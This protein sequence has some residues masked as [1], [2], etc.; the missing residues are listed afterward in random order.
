[1]AN[2]LQEP[3]KHWCENALCTT[4]SWR[5]MLNTWVQPPGLDTP[6]RAL[7]AEDRQE[8][9]S[10]EKCFAPLA[11]QHPSESRAVEGEQ[12]RTW[13]WAAW[14][15]HCI[16]ATVWCSGKPPGSD[17]RLSGCQG[18]QYQAVHR[19]DSQVPEPQQLWCAEAGTCHRLIL[20]FCD[21]LLGFN[22]GA[23]MCGVYKHI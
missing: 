15:D 23:G 20:W 4:Q 11:K 10:P 7:G 9:D 17:D 14:W 2:L 19:Q 16:S 6:S 3:T 5:T 21:I 1:M 13:H 18:S 12:C 8:A 22:V